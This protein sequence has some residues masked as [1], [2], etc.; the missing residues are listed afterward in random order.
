[1]RKRHSVS[2]RA[3]EKQERERVTYV[4]VFKA[5]EKERT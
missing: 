5:T 4:Q 3:M 2:Q 1:M